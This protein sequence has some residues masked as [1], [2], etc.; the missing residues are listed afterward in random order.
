MNILSN[1]VGHFR[2]KIQIEKPSV[3]TPEEE[4]LWREV[5][6]FAALVPSE[7]DPNMG[8][9]KEIKE[10]IAK[11]TYLTREKIEETAALLAIRLAHKE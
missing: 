1:V 9:G 2:K 7:P 5:R 8:R 10:E 3:R 6:K 11:G 4:V